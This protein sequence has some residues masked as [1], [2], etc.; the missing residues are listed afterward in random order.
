MNEEKQ[1]AEFDQLSNDMFWNYYHYIPGKDH[2][3]KLQWQGYNDKYW[4]DHAPKKES[5]TVRTCK[6]GKK[7][8][9][10]FDTNEV[11]EI[12]PKMHSI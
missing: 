6:C 11:K 3:E 9:L 5:Q 12:S 7:F 4:W 8:M 2:F 10:D 1:F